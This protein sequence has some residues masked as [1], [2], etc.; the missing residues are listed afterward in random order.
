MTDRPRVCIGRE[1]AIP[2]DYA[3]LI[4]AVAPRPVLIHAPTGDRFAAAGAVR[5]AANAAA[6]AWPA[7]SK[8]NFVLSTPDGPSDFKG[9]E[10]SAA[11]QWVKAFVQ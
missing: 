3:E 10:I 6:E 4:A 11:L 5:A 2:Y 8:A 7:S 1:A 9:K